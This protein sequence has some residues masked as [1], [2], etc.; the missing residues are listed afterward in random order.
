MVEKEVYTQKYLEEKK[1]YD[2][3]IAKIN[4]TSTLGSIST[5]HSDHLEA[6]SS[7]RG[8]PVVSAPAQAS[9]ISLFVV[10][11]D[12]S[13]ESKRSHATRSLHAESDGAREENGPT[14][15][16]KVGN[17]TDGIFMA[18][19]NVPEPLPATQNDQEPWAEI[20]TSIRQQRRLK[21]RKKT[22]EVIE[23]AAKVVGYAVV[24]TVAVALFP[25]TIGIFF[26]VRRR[27]SHRASMPSIQADWTGVPSKEP[28]PWQAY[29]SADLPAE[30]SNPFE[31]SSTAPE[32]DLIRRLTYAPLPPS[33]I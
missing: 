8:S 4:S 21:R 23:K 19:M 6:E 31:L 25:I 1:K 16:P 11:N 14:A 18:S 24:G 12:V 17:S 2:D 30:L 5:V 33:T 7:T 22:A 13:R 9:P 28:H 15:P 20:S 29:H 10:Q 26:L 27:R 32:L 3:L